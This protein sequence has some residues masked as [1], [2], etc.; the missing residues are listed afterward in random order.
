MAPGEIY[1][2]AVRTLQSIGQKIAV[3]NQRIG[4]FDSAAQSAF[5]KLLHE[6]GTKVRVVFFVAPVSQGP[7]EHIRSRRLSNWL[8]SS[9]ITPTLKQGFPLRKLQ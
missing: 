5:G 9:G 8:V 1:P 4:H 6:I 3:N 2:S 7:R